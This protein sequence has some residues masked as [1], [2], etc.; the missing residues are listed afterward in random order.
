[1]QDGG[2]TL[3]VWN[4]DGDAALHL[5][6]AA[7]DAPALQTTR[8]DARY[9]ALLPARSAQPLD[10]APGVKQLDL[11]LAAGMAAVLFGGETQSVTIW[12]GDHA[13]S[14]TLVGDWPRLVIVNAGAVA[15]PAAVDR[16]PGAGGGLVAGQVMKR[17]FG[18]SGSLSLQVD[19]A[20][21]DRLI[22]AG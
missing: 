1:G 5:R 18:A 13:A 17:F 3:R 22:L 9:A 15:A 4:A 7:I 21:G 16:T 2:E 12:T 11:S 14:R 20:A 10:L 19:A 6:V 8:L